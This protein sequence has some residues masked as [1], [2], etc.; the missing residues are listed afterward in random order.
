MF[1]RAL[2]PCHNH[3]SGTALLT[4]THLP[5][6]LAL[7]QMHVCGYKHPDHSRTAGEAWVP[8][9]LGMK[10]L[11]VRK[12]PE[13]G[14]GR[15]EDFQGMLGIWTLLAPILHHSNMT[16]STGCPWDRF[17]GQQSLLCGKW[18]QEAAPLS[19]AGNT[20]FIKGTQVP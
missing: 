8:G 11:R 9:D 4:H 13:D 10:Q 1:E 20:G 16:F 15:T 14:E 12:Q 17:H 6:D 19:H 5:W 18:N 7:Q 2:P 3:V